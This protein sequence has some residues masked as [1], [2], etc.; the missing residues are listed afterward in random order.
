MS[1]CPV[2]IIS[3]ALLCSHLDSVDGGSGPQVVHAGLQALLPGVEVHGGEFGE[4]WVGDMNVKGHRLIDERTTVS[5]H[6]DHSPLPEYDE[7]K[8][9]TL[10][11]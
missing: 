2:S 7:E 5:G 3:I 6:V 4:I 10:N 9:S 11:V 8:G 1:K